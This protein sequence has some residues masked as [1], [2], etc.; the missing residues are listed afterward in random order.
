[1]EQTK[2]KEATTYDA[3][4]DDECVL[5]LT[6]PLRSDRGEPDP[7]QLLSR[8]V[9]DNGHIANAPIPAEF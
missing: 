1:M 9:L 8:P 5:D 6:P 7:L 4:G 2:G 3:C